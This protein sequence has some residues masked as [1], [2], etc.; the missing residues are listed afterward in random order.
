MKDMSWSYVVASLLSYK[1]LPN[2]KLLSNGQRPL[3]LPGYYII[4]L[5]IWHSCWSWLSTYSASSHCVTEWKWDACC[6]ARVNI[7]RQTWQQQIKVGRDTLEQYEASDKQ[8][9]IIHANVYRYMLVGYVLYRKMHWE[10]TQADVIQVHATVVN[11]TG[12]QIIDNNN[13]KDDDDIIDSPHMN[14]WW[15]EHCR[16]CNRYTNH[17]TF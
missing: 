2:W 6:S 8:I 10:H 3:H 16:C 9:I 7:A 15:E 14:S 17:N 5:Q 1:H 4:L 11:A 12:Q 13:N